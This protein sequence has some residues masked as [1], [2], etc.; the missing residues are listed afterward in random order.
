MKDHGVRVGR[1]DG[2]DIAVPV[3]ARVAAELPR[4]LGRFPH[5]VKG[6]LDVLRGEGLSVVP[7]D[8]VPQEDH[9]VAVAVLPRPLLR[10]LGYRRLES[11]QR[12]HGIEGDEVVEAGL[13]GP[14]GRERH[15]LVDGESLGQVL[16]REHFQDAARLAGE[17]RGSG[18]GGE[19]D[20]EKSSRGDESAGDYDER[21]FGHGGRGY[22]RAAA[23]ST[24]HAWHRAGRLGSAGPARSARDANQNESG[25]VT[26]TQRPPLTTARK[27]E[28]APWCL[29]A[30]KLTSGPLKMSL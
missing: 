23:D 28:L 21:W 14:D 4:G 17:E 1:L 8:A 18:R 12:L 19:G 10:E 9:E 29:S 7:G 3:L 5:H 13:G 27:D 24:W 6:E 20:R 15:R 25:S 11:L 30:A 2:L 16:A 26:R 22:T